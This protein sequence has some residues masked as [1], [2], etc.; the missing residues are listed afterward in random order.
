M[1]VLQIPGG[2]AE[3]GFISILKRS[4]PRETAMNSLMFLTWL[5]FSLNG[6]QGAGSHISVYSPLHPQKFKRL[7][8]NFKHSIKEEF[9]PKFRALLQ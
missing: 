6:V 8:M 5:D 4:K 1:E 2:F 3:G 7:R 9:G